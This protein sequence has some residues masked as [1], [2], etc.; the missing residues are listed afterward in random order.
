MNFC[1][2]SH[3]VLIEKVLPHVE[4]L[5]GEGR[6]GDFEANDKVACVALLVY[7]ALFLYDVLGVF[8][9]EMAVTVD[10]HL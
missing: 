9:C 8:C 1:M 6:N 7:D 10:C 2:E 5:I 4:L 3:W